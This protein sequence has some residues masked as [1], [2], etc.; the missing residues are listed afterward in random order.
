[1]NLQWIN[2]GFNIDISVKDSHLRAKAKIQKK[3]FKK[4][5]SKTT[6]PFI[7]ISIKSK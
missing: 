7:G 4:M 3:S 1:M 5:N 6:W 2:A